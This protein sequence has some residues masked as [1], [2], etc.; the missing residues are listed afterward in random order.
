MVKIVIGFLCVCILIVPL[1]SQSV[2]KTDVLTNKRPH[3]V[4][5]DLAAGQKRLI[6]EQAQ[7][8]LQDLY[9]HRFHKMHYYGPRV[10]PVPT[11]AEIVKNAETMPAGRRR[12]SRLPC[13]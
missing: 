1:H 3:I 8:F 4:F 7:I 6:A 9:V 10:D 12:I 2:V 11:I 13:L 5:P